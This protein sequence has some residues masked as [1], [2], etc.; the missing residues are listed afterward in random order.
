MRLPI[1]LKGFTDI[2][3]LNITGLCID[4]RKVMPGDLFIAY[5]GTQ[6][7]G[8]QYID[9]AIS[10]GAAA[11]IYE[12][13]PDFSLE[14]IHPAIPI[15]P[16]P[17]LQDHLGKIASTFYE[18]PSQNME[19][20]GVTGTNGKTTCTQLIA[21]TLQSLEIPCGV[22]GT[23]GYGFPPEPLT[24][25]VNTTPDPV[26]LQSQLAFLKQKANIVA[27]EVSSHALQQ[28]RTQGIEFD[29]GVFTNLSHDH[30]DYHET[31]ERYWEAKQ[32]LFKNYPLKYTVIN[33]DDTH[34]QALAHDL[35]NK[36]PVIGYTLQE[37][38]VPC[39]NDLRVIKAQQVR[40]SSKGIQA[41]I[42]SPFGEG[43]LKS[44]LL[45]RFNLSNLL[46][47]LG[48]IC[49]L[50]PQLEFETILA[51][52]SK[53]KT[54]SGRMQTLGG[55]KQPL[56]VIDYAHTPDALKQSLMALREHTQGKLWCV[57][58]CGGDRD[59]GK[60][61]LMGQIAEHY[62]DQLIITD[63]NPRNENPKEIVKQITD[64]LSCPWAAEIEHDRKIAIAHAVECAK[65]GDIILIAGKGH[66][67]YQYILDRKIAFNDF[68]QAELALQ[69][70]EL[71][72]A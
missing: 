61:P 11:V 51:H 12:N 17:N 55:K 58:G 64:G 49:L 28:K 54:I 27:M 36:V 16:I 43:L 40:L 3:D 1:L 31:M 24:P 9:Q 42:V 8:R 38:E 71:A 47:S 66:E 5:P 33:L 37:N 29:V 32:I 67:H 18:N 56:I 69:A 2:C 6:T 48:A 60:R 63:D 35:K 50:H 72:Q 59:Q 26:T 53:A 34:G 22:I 65:A 23:L 30:L 57:F 4:S 20:I 62:S 21:Q 14:T 25:N 45:G 44:P 39:A 52:L 19:M 10:Q 46:A 70:K 41:K 13:S 15:I 68:E 7:D